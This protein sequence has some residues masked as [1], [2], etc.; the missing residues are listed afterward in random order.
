MLRITSRLVASVFGTGRGDLAVLG[1]PLVPAAAVADVGMAVAGAVRAEAA[2]WAARLRQGVALVRQQAAA[3]LR[4]AAEVL[5][6]LPV[7][8]EAAP[9]VVVRDVVRP[10]LCR[11]ELPVVEAPV[12][13]VP[14]PMPSAAQVTVEAPT[15]DAGADLAAALEKHGTVR[16]AARALGI[17]ESTFRGRC[18]KLGVKTPG[19][20]AQG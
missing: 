2:S 16:A 1:L 12:E 3:L 13:A 19:R 4:S 10:V 15:P 20:K 5:D 9:V 6:P 14:V 17:A 18:R 11:V 8:Q 7:A